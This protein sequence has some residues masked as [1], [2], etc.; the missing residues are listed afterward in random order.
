[1]YFSLSKRIMNAVVKAVNVFTLQTLGKLVDF[2]SQQPEHG[3]SSEALKSLVDAFKVQYN[4]ENAAP[5][6]RKGA[7]ATGGAGESKK[8]APSQYN[9]FIKETVPRLKET[10]KLPHKELLRMAAKMW[11]E[12]NGGAPAP[13]PVPAAPVA[14]VPEPVAVPTPVAAPV[15]AEKKKKSKK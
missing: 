7:R 3:V 6:S 11:N 13:A 8:R 10:H 12:R 1:M 9:L 5:K 4:A 2:A 14:P 15:V